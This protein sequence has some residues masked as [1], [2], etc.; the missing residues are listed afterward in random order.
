M[1]KIEKMLRRKSR[2]FAVVDAHGVAGQACIAAHELH[3]RHLAEQR[4]RLAPRVGRQS[5]R[6]AGGASLAQ[7][8][9]MLLFL[10][11]IVFGNRQEELKSLGRA[12]SRHDLRGGAIEGIFDVGNDQADDAALAQPHQPRAGIGDIAQ[13]V[14]G[15][16]HPQLG[17]VLD[18]RMVVQG[19]RHRRMRHPQMGGNVLD[20]GLRAQPAASRKRVGTDYCTRLPSSKQESA[21]PAAKMSAL[22]QGF[23]CARYRTRRRTKLLQQVFPDTFAE[24]DGVGER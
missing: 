9:H 4:D 21:L 11:R 6:D 5:D 1:A 10:L 14:G 15:A 8:L 23:R 24:F 17:F 19:T 13:V 3:R 18:V 22:R 7:H 12:A 16:A 2:P 20:R